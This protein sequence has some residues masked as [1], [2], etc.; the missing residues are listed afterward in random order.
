MVPDVVERLEH[1]FVSNG[2][3]G[4]HVRREHLALS[5]DELFAKHVSQ[6]CG[7]SNTHLSAPGARLAHLQSVEARSNVVIGEIAERHHGLGVGPQA[8]LVKR[9]SGEQ[10][11]A[12][13]GGE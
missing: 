5:L 6:H 8:L 10:E 4:Q 7:I 3:R 13:T 11:K 12:L 9:A 1:V 2:G